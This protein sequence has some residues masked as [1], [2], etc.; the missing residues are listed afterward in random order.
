[1]LSVWLVVVSSLGIYGLGWV[2]ILGLRLFLALGICWGEFF[3]LW[4]WGTDRVV[5]LGAGGILCW[6]LLLWLGLILF[7]GFRYFNFGAN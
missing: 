1:M 3:W 2:G 7:L 4:G 5:M 6:V